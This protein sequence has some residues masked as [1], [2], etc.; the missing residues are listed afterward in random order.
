MPNQMEFLG[1]C[2]IDRT[3]GS[4]P[5]PRPQLLLSVDQVHDCIFELND[6]IYEKLFVNLEC[7]YNL[8]CFG[9]FSSSSPVILFR[10]ILFY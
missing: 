4:P 10:I 3:D 7:K 6:I 9:V 5:P 8:P 2:Q 1:H